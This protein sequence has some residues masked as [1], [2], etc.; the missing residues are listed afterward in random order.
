PPP[1]P[2][3][4]G[5]SSGTAWRACPTARAAAARPLF[6]PED[7]HKVLVLATTPPADVGVPTSHWSPDDL[8][9]QIL[10]DAHYRDMSRSTIQRILADAD[11][12]PHRCRYWPKSHDSD[13]EA[14]ALDVCGLYLKALALYA[15]G[16]SVGSVD[17]K[18]STQ[19]LLRLHATLSA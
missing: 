1:A 13:F 4:A 16:E 14:K 19:A 6:P 8:A 5:A 2:G 11:L 17:E 15:R 18:T 7:R 9:Y 10:R 3:G 12:Q